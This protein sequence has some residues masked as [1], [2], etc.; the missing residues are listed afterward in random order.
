MYPACWCRPRAR[1]RVVVILEIGIDIRLP[2]KLVDDEIQV[3]MFGLG[4][5]FHKQVPGN[6]AAFH[7][8]LIHPENVAAPLRL[9]SAEAAG[10][11]QDARPHQPTRP[12][13]QP[14]GFG[15]VQD[16][17]VAAVPIFEALSNLGLCGAR[18]QAE[19][20]VWEML[21]TLLCC[22]GK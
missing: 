9:V 10:S 4:H 13:F 22:G 5:V 18:L 17:V 20:G 12:R 16:P 2:I 15:K 19:K 1:V 14:V 11:V 3:A 6:I 7:H 21:P 8:A